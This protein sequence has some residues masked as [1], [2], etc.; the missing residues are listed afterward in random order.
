MADVSPLLTLAN[1]Q[2]GAA[3][4]QISSAIS[5]PNGLA[6]LS[7]FIRFAGTG[8]TSV[9]VYLQQLVD[10][11]A[12]VGGVW[13]DLLNVRFSE[14]GAKLF[15]L[16]QGGVSSLVDITEAG[17]SANTV[18]N[19]GVVPLF[20]A[21]RIKTVSAGTWTNGLVSVVAMPRG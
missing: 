4:T 6:G 19:N 10:G 1:I 21:C 14:A 2:I 9:D 16:Q 18:L 20:G 13:A 5:L 3:G 17:I 7:G 11:L 12:G 15:S 8:G